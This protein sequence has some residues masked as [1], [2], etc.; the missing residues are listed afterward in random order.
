MSSQT[1]QI[2]ASIAWSLPA[3]IV[4]IVGIVLA[5]LRWRR[6]PTVSAILVASLAT[7]LVSGLAFRITVV[8]LAD[9]RG[10]GYDNTIN[11]V[12]GSLG[13]LLAVIR[14]V[15]W[16]ALLVAIFGWRTG[17]NGSSS[18][19]LQ[20]SIRGLIVVTFAVAVL[21]S[22]GRWLV[23]IL[24]ESAPVMIQFVDD[25]PLVTCFGIGIWM[26]I[27]RWPSHPWVS[28]LA[29]W[30]FTLGIAV[31]LVPQTII[32]IALRSSYYSSAF[33][34]LIQLTATIATTAYVTMA[35]AAALGW[36][37]P[38]STFHAPS[39]PRES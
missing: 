34:L 33:Y 38:A 4:A 14:T 17:S 16:S 8:I 7:S 35:I 20:F 22:L 31:M 26:A 6:H 21:C 23:G 39:W 13:I 15:C 36:R 27:A 11:L 29:V 25:L 5:M 37:D 30:S 3:N 32:L 24:G 12:L 2:L 1:L 10:G 19:P 18:V 9:Q 28:F